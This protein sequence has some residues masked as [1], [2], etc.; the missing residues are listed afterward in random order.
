MEKNDIFA[1]LLFYRYPGVSTLPR[2]ITKYQLCRRF[3]D[4]LS[5]LFPS[6]PGS[7]GRLVQGMR[8]IGY[9][10]KSEFRRI[11]TRTSSRYQRCS[12]GRSCYSP[13]IDIVYTNLR[14][15][16]YA[17]AS[18]SIVNIRCR[19]EKLVSKKIV[20]NAIQRSRLMY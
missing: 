20:F 3:G 6:V 4:Y 11:C 10:N 15:G 9:A 5:A 12:H 13:V 16:H 7:F 2:P 14:V 8:I 18:L 17:V 19:S 1:I